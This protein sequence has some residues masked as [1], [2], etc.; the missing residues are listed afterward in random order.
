MNTYDS[1]VGVAICPHPPLLIPQ[2]AAGAAAETDELR[3][4]CDQVVARLLATNPAQIVV[5]GPQSPRRGLGAF[6]P[7]VDGLAFASA[8]Q[9][10]SLA[11]GAWLL[12]RADVMRRF[13]AVRPD[14]TPATGWPDL[15][16]L[17]SLPGLTAL[18]V[19][20]D[21]SARR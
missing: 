9:P 7:G 15:S 16:S 13:V 18:L 2:I 12:D 19:M 17:A 6:A 10:L 8:E 1:I 11:I 21:G 20:A 4:A 5:V 14:G 3:A